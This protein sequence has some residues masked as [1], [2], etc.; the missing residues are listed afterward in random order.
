MKRRLACSEHVDTLTVNALR[1][2]VTALLKRSQQADAPLERLE[3]D[4]ADL[5]EENAALRLENTHLKLA[6]QLV[7]D[8]IA[9]PNLSPR[10]P[11]RRAR[12]CSLSKRL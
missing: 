12:K 7:R 11:S 3:V 1:G 8:E 2:L 6:N 10:P 5:R 4:N 9:R